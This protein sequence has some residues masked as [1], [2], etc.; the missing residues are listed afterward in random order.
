MADLDPRVPLVQFPF[1]AGIDEGTQDEV[2]E[3]GAAWLVLENGRQ[4]KMGG[5]STRPGFTALSSGRLDA[6]T[7]SAGLK[8]FAHRNDT[9]RITETLQAEA[10][11]SQATAWSPL[12]RVPECAARLI[13]MPTMGTSATLEDVDATNG[14]IA[15]SWLSGTGSS[16]TAY[17]AIVDQ[18]TG[19]VIRAPEVVGTSTSLAP[20]LLAVQGA[21]FILARY[22]ATG[23]KI[24]A[25]Y[26]DTT[27]PATI[28][29]GWVAFGASLCVDC[30]GGSY[31]LHSLPHASMPRVALLYRNSGG[32]TDQITLVT[33]D[34]TG[35]AQTQTIL[36][37]SQTPNT[38]A[39]GGFATDTLWLAWDEGVV[40]WVQGVD[41]FA[42]SSDL[43]TRIDPIALTTAVAYLGIA[44]STEL[45]RA[46]VWATDTVVPQSAMRGVST[47]SGAAS[48]DG[49]SYTNVTAV[50]M[51]RKPFHLAGRYYSAFY[52]VDAAN[53]Q[54]GFI[55]CD[56]TEDLA[57]L[58]PIANPAPD[59]ASYG[60]FGFGKFVAGTVSTSLYAGFN[61]KR[62]AIADGTALLALDFAS[63]HRW[64]SVTHGE[65]TF[66]SGGLL[67]YYDGLRV[68]EV[69]FM[70]RPA[71]PT[72]GT[73]GTGITAVTGWRY[74]AVYEE[75]DA[76]GNWCVSGLSD[77]S[78][79]TGA[80]SN[81]TVSVT[82]TPLSITSR[83]SSSAA[84]RG[85]RVA[86]YR[87]L[88]GGEAPY[89]RV[90]TVL[91]DYVL[92]GVIFADATTDA[93]LATRSK[94]YAQPGV[95]GTSQ[96][97][98][99][100][101][102]FS[103]IASYNG[104]L[105]GASG[106]TVWYSGQDITGEATWFN[107]I[108][109]VPIPGEGDITALFVMD[110]TLF[111]AKRREIYALVGEPPSDN[112]ASGGLGIPRRLAVDVGCID[113]RSTCVT[114]LGTFFQSDRGIEVLTRAQ[115]VEW[116][117]QQVTDTM[118]SFPVVT[119]A[120]VEPVSSCVLIELAA[121]ESSGS[122]SGA[123]RTL[124][125]DLILR[126]W[127]STD[128]RTSVAGTV[129]APSQSAC[130]IY[131]GTAWR[132][133]W[134][135]TTGSVHYE[136]SASSL[137]ANG[138]FVA[139][140]AVSANIKV[141]GMQGMQHVNK[142]LLLAKK[143]TSHDLSLSLA[144]NYAADYK[145]ARL[146]TADDLDAFTLPMQQLE[147]DMHDDARCEAVRAQFQDAAPSTGE[148]AGTGRAATWIALCFEVVPKGGAYKL[149]DSAR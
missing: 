104:M 105:V 128:R 15:T 124:V 95:P 125:Y 131:T 37:D 127:V 134:L 33:F 65:A 139:K 7:A 81:K 64:Q 112:G 113:Q 102:F 119:S 70:N 94:L 5:Y 35:V 117:G 136:N 8:L 72:T 96:D 121:A 111:A 78:S 115:T 12:G 16:Y 143:I 61:V 25:F 58:R 56:W 71:K 19:A 4:D 34:I 47:V 100:P 67:S 116:V 55:V 23:T 88:D 149:P 13:D 60:H 1:T 76:E 69:G 108:F 144:Y 52:A 30:A 122:V 10:Y 45:G 48:P 140:R 6:S 101:P 79:S 87:T 93:I 31:V 103:C 89:Y 107:P 20:P 59:V 80:V 123:G 97:R 32:G 40:V 46:R 106:S 18:V 11:S 17:V 146:W 54:S 39:L 53:S 14:Y 22:S 3:G 91:S 28:A 42:I 43:A 142:V 147:H 99:P 148:D 137:D 85:T 118:E 126:R 26:L 21:H 9:V 114:A 120:T 68:A 75:T 90:G 84:A 73:S 63:S 66:L 129:D 109:Q 82:T 51:A 133:A 138:S 38:V 110:G 83:A 141:S 74:I 44:G 132:Y 2:L 92:T 145:T 27:S 77:P 57:Y 36:T 98:R 29:T 135:S 86:V 41:P 24:Q 130:M 62:S 49:A 50:W